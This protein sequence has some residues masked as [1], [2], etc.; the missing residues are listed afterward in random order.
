MKTKSVLLLRGAI[1]ML[2]AL[3]LIGDLLARPDQTG[4]SGIF[5]MVDGV[6]GAL[7]WFAL[8]KHPQGRWLSGLAFADAVVRFV[9]GLMAFVFPSIQSRVI[10][11]VIFFGAL[12]VACVV[13]GAVGIIYVLMMSGRGA[14]GEPRG[15]VLPALIVSACTLL[16]GLGLFVGLSSAEGRRMLTIALIGSVGLTYLLTGLR[17]NRP[18]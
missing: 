17:L 18:A 7:L 11:S 16:F 12:V 8:S 14:Q 10:G 15:G 3:Y 1:S 5:A 4:G 6:L 2:F 13:L 9:A